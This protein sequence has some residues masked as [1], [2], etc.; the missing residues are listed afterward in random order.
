MRLVSDPVFGE[1]DV[2]ASAEELTEL[3]RA[4]AEGDGFV[5]ATSP[6]PGDSLAGV[7]VREAPG[8][9]V[10]IEL[11]AGRRVLVI[12]GD[13]SA[14]AIL[15]ANIQG[16]ATTE[17]AGHLHV[18]HFPEHPYLVAGS[19]PLVVNSPHGGMPTRR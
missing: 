4:V 11:D 3:A 18:D 7:E 17:G 13:P 19:V 8:P 15:A 2:K 10:R 12:S 9:G 1:V 14:R 6:M 5:G 16:V